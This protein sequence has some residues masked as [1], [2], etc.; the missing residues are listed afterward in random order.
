MLIFDTVGYDTIGLRLKAIDALNVNFIKETTKY[1]DVAGSYKPK[2]SEC[3]YYHGNLD[4]LKISTSENGL[5]IKEGSLCKWYKGNNIETLGRVDTKFAIEKLSDTLHLPMDKAFVHRLDVAKTIPIKYPVCVYLAHLGELK[6]FKRMPVVNK[7]IGEGLYYFPNNKEQNMILI[8]YDKNAE[9]G[10]KGCSIYIHYSN[11]HL[12]R[13]EQRYKSGFSKIFGKLIRANML[14]N[15]DFYDD[16][17]FRWVEAYKAIQKVNNISLDFTK[18]QGKR[19]LYTMGILALVELEGGQL[20]FL[21]QIEEARK[22]GQINNKQVFDIREAIN[23]SCNKLET[24]FTVMNDCIIEL[25][26]KMEK[27]EKQY[28]N[29]SKINKYE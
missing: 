1:F 8:F 26:R 27:I 29:R 19:D 18:L 21:S 4:G 15:R 24:G 14:Y 7:N 22:I 6:G 20:A 5:S 23:D 3:R 11:K 13:F 9:H 12:F 2:N 25:D 16:I 10:E 17:V 28:D